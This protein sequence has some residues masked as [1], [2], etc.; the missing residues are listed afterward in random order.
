[1]STYN[2]EKYIETSLKSLLD[3]TFQEFEIIIVD[4]DFYQTTEYQLSCL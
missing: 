4:N 2:E 1:M 3:Q